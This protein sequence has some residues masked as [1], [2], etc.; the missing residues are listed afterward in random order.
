MANSDTHEDNG[1]A[2][3][4]ERDIEENEIMKPHVSNEGDEEFGGTKARQALERKLLRKLDLR[5][6]ILI[7]I[8]ILNYVRNIFLR[9]LLILT[10]DLF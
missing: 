8:Y 4:T 1:K 10:L 7:V 9:F 5:M 3:S 2:G 6:S